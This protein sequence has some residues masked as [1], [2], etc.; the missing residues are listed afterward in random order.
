M[1]DCIP[2]KCKD[3]HFKC[4]SSN[5]CIPKNYLCNKIS[6]CEDGSDEDPIMCNLNNRTDGCTIS[7]FKCANKKCIKLSLICNKND[8][9][10]K[11]TK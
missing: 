5:R 7:Q 10:G 6:D 8:D 9:C 4:K 11:K 1:K 2:H 3:D